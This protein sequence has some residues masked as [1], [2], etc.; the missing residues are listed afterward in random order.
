MSN[1]NWSLLEIFVPISLLSFGGGTAITMVAVQTKLLDTGL[2]TASEFVMLVALS[3]FVP[4]PG[5]IIGP[6]AGWT[7]GGAI[8]AII[9][10]MALIVP[11]SIVCYSATI[12]WKRADGHP[13]MQRIQG[14]LA[15]VSLGLMFVSAHRILETLGHSLTAWTVCIVA[16]LL[17]LNSNLPEIVLIACGGVFVCAMTFMTPML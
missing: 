16:A 10:A 15:P 14:A 8:G 17:A 6:M 2:L 3:R 1:N 5:S 13:F 12:L 9:A 11:S 7:I 4:G